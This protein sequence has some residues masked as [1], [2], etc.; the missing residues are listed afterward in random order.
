[1]GNHSQSVSV[2]VSKSFVCFVSVSVP[3]PWQARRLVCHSLFLV[4]LE[5]G[6]G[7]FLVFRQVM[8][9]KALLQAYLLIRQIA[10]RIRGPYI[11]VIGLGP[12]PE[13]PAADRQESTPG[14]AAGDMGLF[15]LQPGQKLN[16]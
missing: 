16:A 15:V 3:A 5:G 9:D 7:V 13:V 2:S 11:A 1:M 6:W 10:G 14:T 12:G 8:N 4:P